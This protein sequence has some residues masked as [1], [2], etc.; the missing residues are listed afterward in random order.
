M[1]LKRGAL[2]HWFVYVAA[3]GLLGFN[4]GNFWASTWYN[5]WWF[6]LAASSLWLSF[7]AAKKYRSAPLFIFFA[8]SLLSGLYVYAWA[9]HPFPLIFG[10]S[11]TGIILQNVG[12]AIICCLLS[13]IVFIKVPTSLTEP[14]KKAMALIFAI[15]LIKTLS[16]VNASGHYNAGYY[17][18]AFSGNSSMNGCLM[19]CLLP[20]FLSVFARPWMKILAW[21]LTLVGILMT[22][23]SVP[24]GVFAAVTFVLIVKS[25]KS[26]FVSVALIASI[27]IISYFSIP[28]LLNSS[29]RFT[30]WGQIMEGWSKDYSHFFGSGLGTGFS[31]FKTIQAKHY[32]PGIEF[33]AY[34]WLHNDWL[35][36]IFELGYI[37]F[38]AAF[39]FY[40][41]LVKRS[42]NNRAL[43][44]SLIGFGAAGMLNYPMRLPIHAVTLLFTCW[45]I[46]QGGTHGK[47]TKA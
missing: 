46:L 42:W 29:G 4:V 13:L 20:Y 1:L 44:S 17:R 47:E 15:T 36:L 41:E 2:K 6:L 14:I 9:G 25:R 31:L 3:I 23:S 28:D 10:L 26:F 30:A 12:Y 24:I 18:A 35:Q 38:S 8:T 11:G 21:G 32:I 45:L 7:E 43:L 27:A 19:A 22:E 33:E 40:L 39:T 16:Q 5:K 34:M 37:G